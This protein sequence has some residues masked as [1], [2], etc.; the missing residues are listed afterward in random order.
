MSS[1]VP[2]IDRLIATSTYRLMD[3][4]G[5]VYFANARFVSLRNWFPVI[6]PV[7]AVDTLSFVVAI[8]DHFLDDGN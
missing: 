4:L 5:E 1:Q 6:V 2:L 8:S 3:T 7:R